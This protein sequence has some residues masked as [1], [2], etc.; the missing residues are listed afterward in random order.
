M[1]FREGEAV[2]SRSVSSIQFIG[3][4]FAGRSYRRMRNA[5]APLQMM[6]GARFQRN[7]RRQTINVH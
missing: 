7:Q 5:V 3:F 4:D 2:L 1:N 6:L